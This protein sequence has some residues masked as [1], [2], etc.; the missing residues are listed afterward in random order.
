MSDQT[1]S[2]LS[3]S[4]FSAGYPRRKVIENLTVPHLP[5][6]KITALLGPN[7]S[8]KSTLMRA[9]AGLGPCRGEL[10]LEGEN[11]LTQPFSRRAEQVVGGRYERP[12][13]IRAVAVSLQRRPCRT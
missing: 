2:G 4:H 9:M 13:I 11:L 1:L 7:G 12:D 6:G 5:R 10:L 8:G 3:L